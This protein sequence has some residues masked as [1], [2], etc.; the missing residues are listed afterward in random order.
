MYPQS[1]VVFNDFVV[2]VVFVVVFVVFVVVVFFVVVFVVVVFIVLTSNYSFLKNIH[3]RK[4]F[5]PE[6]YS[7]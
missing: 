7:T 3:P 5:T 6:K 4:I 2:V 1:L